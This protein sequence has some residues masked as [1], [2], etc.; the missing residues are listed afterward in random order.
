M[1]CGIYLMIFG[2]TTRSRRIARVHRKWRLGFTVLQK[3]DEQHHL[4]HFKISVQLISCKDVWE[5]NSWKI[6]SHS[7]HWTPYTL[8]LALSTLLP[9][10]SYITLSISQFFFMVQSHD[11]NNLPNYV[12][13][14][15][16]CPKKIIRTIQGLVHGQPCK[17]LSECKGII[18]WASSNF[19]L[20][21]IL[22]ARARTSSAR[23]VTKLLPRAA[24][25]SVAAYPYIHYP[26]D[27]HP[28]YTDIPWDWR[29]ATIVTTWCWGP[30]LQLHPLKL[31]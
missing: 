3:V 31:H 16:V 4:L 22:L 27:C 5:V 20:R 7:L 2:E 29:A 1:V 25:W 28:D 14:P 15:R 24:P 13:I 19:L 17:H 23:G 30:V 10:S 9:L 8:A 21:K 11:L 12:A 18:H 6:E 26:G